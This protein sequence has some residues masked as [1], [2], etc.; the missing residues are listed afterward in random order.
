MQ[1][2]KEPV[3]IEGSYIGLRDIQASEAE[4]YLFFE[5]LFCNY[6]VGSAIIW[7]EAESE[8]REDVRFHLDNF[9][10]QVRNNNVR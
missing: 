2:P 10:D 3:K 7:G 6:L 5:N 4:Y 1:D 8:M 9:I